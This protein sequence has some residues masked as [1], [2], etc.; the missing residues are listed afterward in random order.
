[1][2]ET[3]TPHRGRSIQDYFWVLVKRRWTVLVVFFIV[4]GI[5]AFNTFSQ[6]P[7]YKATVQLLIERYAPRYLEQPGGAGPFDYYSEEFYQ[8]QYKLLESRALA[9]KLVDKLELKNHPN[10]APLFK[11]LADADEAKKQR[12]EEALVSGIAGGVSVEPIRQSSLVNLNYSHPDPKLAAFLANGLARCYIEQSLDLRFA[13]SQE[14]AAWLKQKVLESRNKLEESETKLNQ[15]KREHN[16]VTVEDKE[17]ITSQKLE[18]LNK[19]LV[20]AQTHRMEVETR[21]KEVSQGRPIAQVLNNGLIQAL[22][23]QEAKLVTEQS[24]LSKKFGVE[25]PRM[26]QLSNELAATRAKIGAEMAQ[27]VQTIKNE[28]NMAKEQEENLKAALNVSKSDSQDL[29]DRAIHYRVLLREVETNRALYENVLKS[30]K[31]ITTT[32]NVPSTNIRI[33]YPAT[34]PES[35]ISPRKAHNLFIASILGLIL[36]VGLAFGLESLDTTLKTP[37]DVEG[38]L[39]IPNLAMIPHF[40]LASGNPAHQNPGLVVHQATQHVASES[41]RTLRTSILFSTP[42]H[43]PRIILVTSSLPGEGKTLTA[44]NLATAMAKNEANVLLVD[45]DLRKP[46]LHELFQVPKE[47][48]LSNFLVGEIDDLPFLETLVP[49]LFVVP[50]GPIPPNPSELL[51]SMRMQEFLNRAQERYGR[52]ILD[53]PPLISATDAAILSTQVEGVLLVVKAEAVPRKAAMEGRD[54]LQELKAHILGTVLNDMPVYRD[55]YFYNYNY[56]HSRYY[57]SPREEGD[58]PRSRRAWRPASHWDRLGWVKGRLDDLRKRFS[59]RT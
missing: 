45:S 19:E 58:T 30:L 10:Y 54:K 20:A 49:H 16:I 27:V 11:N 34:V 39:E 22:K 3:P 15:Y 46:S 9:K 37:A 13:A 38:W 47:P 29:S 32:E 6:T 2:E 24:E 41:Y 8:T 23:T 4:L 12:A 48:G 55:G 25:H 7:I 50:S 56:Y 5:G 43:S 17:S 52:V 18:Q 28:Y 59:S 14:A 1:M 53:S 40:D 42:G 33:V 35:P 21:F 44:A 36:G 51:G 57:S 31:T 26:I